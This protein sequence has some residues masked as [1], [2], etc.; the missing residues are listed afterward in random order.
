MS[1][2]LELSD[3]ALVFGFSYLNHARCTLAFGGDHA[4]TEITPRARAALD[5]LLAAGVVEK[6]QP[7][8]QWPGREYYRGKV[9]IGPMMKAR[10]LNPLDDADERFKWT[11]FA[12][13]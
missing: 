1:E 3:D 10:N 4:E 8:D 2:A 12:K 11:T 7:W 6:A 5:E 13:K 9:A